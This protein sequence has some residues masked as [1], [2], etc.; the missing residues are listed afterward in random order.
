MNLEI[1]NRIHP[2]GKVIEST[3]VE[4][5]P[6]VLF[7]GTWTSDLN[8][9]VLVAKSFNTSSQFYNLDVNTIGGS[10]TV[11]AKAPS[12]THT[13][14]IIA[15]YDWSS[16]GSTTTSGN[17]KGTSARVRYCYDGDS[18]YNWGSN[19]L[20]TSSVGGGKAHNN[21]QE[22]TVARRWIRVA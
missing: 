19:T 2:I 7:G 4:F 1:L 15:G 11:V 17:F 20:R 13:A 3:D 5:N 10:E 9:V 8:G 16:S 6:N 18:S 21:M 12:H 14:S 22:Y